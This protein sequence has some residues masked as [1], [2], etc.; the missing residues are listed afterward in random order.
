V[1]AVGWRWVVSGGGGLAE[2][3]RWWQWVIGGL[4]IALLPEK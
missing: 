1:V 2:G 4:A 3:Y